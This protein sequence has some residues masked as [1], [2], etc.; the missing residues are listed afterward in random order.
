MNL[1][2]EKQNKYLKYTFQ[3]WIGITY[4]A[5]ILGYMLINIELRLYVM[6]FWQIDGDRIQNSYYCLGAFSLTDCKFINYF[7]FNCS[8]QVAV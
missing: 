2:V 8:A 5:E 3:N 1:A 6:E 4:F 7:Q